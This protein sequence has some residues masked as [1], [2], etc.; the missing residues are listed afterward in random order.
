MT[1]YLTGRLAQILIV[2]LLMSLAI[3]LL[4]GLMPGDP[5]DLLIGANPRM[6]SADAARLRIAYGLDQPLWTR[7]V[8]WLGLALQGDFGF[9][10]NFAQPVLDRKSVV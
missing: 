10:R 3:Y 7:Y 6:T 8:T 1:R 5:I 4:I 2:L 9:S